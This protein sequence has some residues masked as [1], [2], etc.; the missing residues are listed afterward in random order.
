MVELF[1]DGNRRLL[2]DGLSFYAEVRDNKD[3]GAQGLKNTE[4]TCAGNFRKASPAQRE[5]I[6]AA[7]LAEL[8]SRQ[9]IKLEPGITIEENILLNAPLPSNLGFDDRVRIWNQYQVV[10]SKLLVRMGAEHQMLDSIARVMMVGTLDGVKTRMALL[11]VL[12][13]SALN[14]VGKH[15]I[16]E[17]AYRLA[18]EC[19]LMELSAAAGY[20]TFCFPKLVEG[21]MKSGKMKNQSVHRMFGTFIFLNTMLQYPMNDQ[22]VLQALKRVNEMHRKYAVADDPLLFKYIALNMFYIGPS[23]RPDLTPLE[24]YALCG[25]TGLVSRMMAHSISGTTKELEAFI[26]EYEASGMFSSEEQSYLRRSAIEIAH[27]SKQGLDKIPTISSAR[28]HG[29]VP[30]R[31]K[32]ILD[33][34][35]CL[36]LDKP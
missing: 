32:K 12:G 34:D 13:Y 36:R 25:L 31:V 22:R 30:Y 2:L 26:G 14:A 3:F 1:N 6:L 35:S 7:H 23:M 18:G 16:G 29:Y 28:I 21:L 17:L 15:S 4:N 9:A 24:R 20:R 8:Q 19:C 5:E 27:A 11:P 10:I 33:L